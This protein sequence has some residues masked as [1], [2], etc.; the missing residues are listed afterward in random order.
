[1][2]QDVRIKPSREVEVNLIR[3]NFSCCA[4]YCHGWLS[5]ER[6]CTGSDGPS[7]LIQTTQAAIS[8]IS[9]CLNAGAP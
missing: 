9:K 1:M 4:P 3:H 8:Y 5:Q 6:M 7:Q 2:I